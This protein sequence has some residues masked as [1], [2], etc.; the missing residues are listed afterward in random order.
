MAPSMFPRSSAATVS[1]PRSMRS[2]RPASN[3]GLADGP[4][5]QIALL[6]HQLLAVGT[7]VEAQKRL[8]VRGA[9]VEVPMLVVDGDAV[10]TRDL[11]VAET[12]LEA[13]QRSV[14]I[15]DRRVDLAGDEV[16]GAQRLEQF[17]Q[18]GLLA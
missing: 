1:V 15:V 9:H 5:D 16:L 11:T 13:S 2:A 6:L 4:E 10:Q 14:D 17:G 7:E 18:R 12:L 3:S 8:R